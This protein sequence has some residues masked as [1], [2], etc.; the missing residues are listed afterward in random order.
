MIVIVKACISSPSLTRQLHYHSQLDKSAARSWKSNEDTFALVTASEALV[1]WTEVMWPPVCGNSANQHLK[2]WDGCQAEAPP[3]PQSLFFISQRRPWVN[4]DR[5]AG[6]H[7][8]LSTR[9]HAQ[10]STDCMTC[11]RTSPPLSF[12]SPSLGF[13]DRTC[14]ERL[15]LLT[16]MN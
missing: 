15:N 9:S 1:C 3:A 12:P 16:F 2:S 6:R 8:H 11:Q 10:H 5:P 13:C 4:G 14:L 7:T